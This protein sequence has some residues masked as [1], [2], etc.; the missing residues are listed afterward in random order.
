MAY[1]IKTT[2]IENREGILKA[3]RG[4]KKPNNIKI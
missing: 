1:Y 2:S 3:V 4:K